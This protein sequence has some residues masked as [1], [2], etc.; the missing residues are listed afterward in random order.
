MFLDP[1]TFARFVAINVSVDRVLSK[2]DK[3][4]FRAIKFGMVSRASWTLDDL[5]LINYISCFISQEEVVFI[6]TSTPFQ[7]GD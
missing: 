2:R 1:Y 4:K 6:I 5:K 3:V 7:T